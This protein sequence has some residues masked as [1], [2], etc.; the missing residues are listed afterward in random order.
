LSDNNLLT[1]NDARTPA[2]LKPSLF[3]ICLSLLWGGNNVA[4][5][6][7]LGYSGPLQVGWLRFVS[8]G[9]VTVI[10]MLLRR[11]SFVLNKTDMKAMFMIGILFSIQI[12]FMNYGQHLTTAGHATALNATFPIWA[13]VLAH[14]IIPADKLTKL[15]IVAIFLSYSG[16]LAIVFGDMRLNGSGVSL[17]G[18]LLSVTSAMLLGSRLVLTSNFA[19][20][21]SEA[22]IMLGQLVIGTISFLIMSYLLEDITYVFESRFVFAIIYQGCLIA[23]FGFLANAWLMKRY[24]PSSITFFAFIQPLSGV[25]IA[26]L[27]LK[28][29]PGNGLLSGL[30]LIIF[31]AIVFSG[32]SY[33]KSRKLSH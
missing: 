27:I 24:L 33:W 17:R 25:I 10:Y 3:Q 21:M 11:E 22:K 12:V 19:Q 7:A 2:G 26:S 29:D 5:K 8:G 28:E 32:E 6:V 23:G 13:A 1:N 9:V 20:N 31:G 18:D 14:L 16:V 30:F 4:I 15:K